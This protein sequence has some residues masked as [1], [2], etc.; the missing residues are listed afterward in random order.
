MSDSYKRLKAA[1]LIAALEDFFVPEYIA[2]WMMAKHHLQSTN[3]P[4]LVPDRLACATELKNKF[5]VMTPWSNPAYRDEFKMGDARMSMSDAVVG[6]IL[7]PTAIDIAL[8]SE[9][10]FQFMCAMDNRY[11]LLRIIHV[12]MTMH[13]GLRT[14]LIRANAESY[15][16]N[17]S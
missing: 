14:A 9:Y 4:F 11:G 7:I 3:S 8:L 17:T 16:N 1:P 2:V 10:E 12:M 13:D 6:V 15:H 5:C